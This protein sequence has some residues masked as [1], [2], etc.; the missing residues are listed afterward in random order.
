MIHSKDQNIRIAKFF[1]Q[2][3]CDYK[4]ILTN[5]SQNTIFGYLVIPALLAVS[6][7]YIKNSIDNITSLKVLVNYSINYYKIIDPF[8][9]Q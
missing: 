2:Q 5:N 3:Y 6:N 1:S 4:N 7:A 8:N 9:K